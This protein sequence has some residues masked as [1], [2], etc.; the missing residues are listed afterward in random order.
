[1]NQN[2]NPVLSPGYKLIVDYT[3][4]IFKRFTAASSCE[5]RR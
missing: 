4:V 3:E 5:W 1:M 2:Q